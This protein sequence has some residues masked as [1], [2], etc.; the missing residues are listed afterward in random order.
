MRLT[1]ITRGRAAGAVLA[2]A[3]VAAGTVGLAGT[4]QAATATYTVSPKTGPGGTNTGGQPASGAK[5]LTITGTG[6]KTGSTVNVANIRWVAKG[7]ACTTGATALATFAVNSATK[8]TATVPADTLALTATTSGGVTTYT[9]KDYTFCV[10]DGTP[11]LLG[12]A[13][14]AVYPVPTIDDPL[15]P[16]KGSASGGETV[17]ISGT[18]FTSAAVVKFGSVLGTKPKVAKDGKSLTV[19]APAG[20]A[21]AT[22]VEVSVTTEGGTAT[23]GTGTDNDYT[24][25]NAI[26]V[27]PTTTTGTSG[28]VLTITGTG[29]TAAGYDWTSAST[30]DAASGVFLFQGAY[31]WLDTVDNGIPDG[32]SQTCNAVQVVSD[33]ELSCKLAGAV[34]DGAYIVYVVED[35]TAIASASAVSSSAAYTAADF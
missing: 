5:V 34:T 4:S 9:K 12:Q 15:T 13:A 11:T 18:G 3:M 33:T 16:T 26:S 31:A 30:V 7:T 21:S 23:V 6:F 14:Y 19:T 35:K 25:V 32:A 10:Y 29:F 28:D 1:K 27:S 22:A 17:T 20:T 2:A 8:I 24:Y